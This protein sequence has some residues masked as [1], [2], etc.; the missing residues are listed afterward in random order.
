MVIIC[1]FFVMREKITKNN[2]L[3]RQ[4]DYF[5]DDYLSIK[6]YRIEVLLLSGFKRFGCLNADNREA[7]TLQKE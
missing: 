7:T 5:F 1:E 4:T 2:S 3:T 6:V